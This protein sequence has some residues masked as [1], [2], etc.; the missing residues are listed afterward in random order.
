MRLL[1]AVGR[2][3]PPDQN[4]RAPI[5]KELK[6]F[7]KSFNIW[8]VPRYFE[9]LGKI[10]FSMWQV[11]L[12]E[13]DVMADNLHLCLAF[14]QPHQASKVRNGPTDLQFLLHTPFY[15]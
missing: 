15:M 4:Y 12:V 9:N 3:Q 14:E 11:H 1:K 2:Y 6:A 10:N 13:P 5:R 7:D 8:T